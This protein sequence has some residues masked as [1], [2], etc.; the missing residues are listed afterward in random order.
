MS[1]LKVRTR[2]TGANATLRPGEQPTI[3]TPTNGRIDVVTGVDLPGFN[4]LDLL[5]A[6]VAACMVLSARIA[7]GRLGVGDRLRDV[8]ADVSGSKAE[9]DVSR[10]GQFRIVLAIEG[11][12]DAATKRQIAE[13]AETICTVSNTLR[14]EPEFVTVFAE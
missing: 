4:P 8:R 14:G 13:D 3:T 10:I 9:G 1:G 2:Q 11:D 7:A 5:Y 12:I 6:S